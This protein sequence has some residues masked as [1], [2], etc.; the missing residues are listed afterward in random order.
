[1]T[2]AFHTNL[3]II[4]TEKENISLK[5]NTFSKILIW[6]L[7]G[8]NCSIPVSSESVYPNP[9]PPVPEFPGT[10][11]GIVVTLILMCATMSVVIYYR[12]RFNRL[13]TELAH[14]HY[15]AGPDNHQ[16]NRRKFHKNFIENSNSDHDHHHFDNPVYSTYRN[17]NSMS[18]TPLN[19][20]RLHNRIV[21]NIN[22]DREKAAAS[23]CPRISSSFIEEDDISDTTSERGML[24]LTYI[25]LCYNCLSS[26]IIHLFCH[27]VTMSES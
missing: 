22:S 26:L 17:T 23:S 16:G 2:P 8:P 24:L 20:A 21:K 6:Q 15:H 11:L 14:V 1:M 12:R 19:N 27:N 3:A 25:F 10:I 18:G 13:K 5:T 7:S 9:E 4:L